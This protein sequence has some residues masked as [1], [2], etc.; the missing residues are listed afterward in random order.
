ML[1]ISALSFAGG[2]KR[3]HSTFGCQLGKVTAKSPASCDASLATIVFVNGLL[4]SP[5]KE[6]QAEKLKG[7][8]E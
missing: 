4:N 1:P 5:P 6:A 3:T 7:G 8:A 2:R